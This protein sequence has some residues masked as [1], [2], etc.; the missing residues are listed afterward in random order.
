MQ[1]LCTFLKFLFFF[2]FRSRG[3][4][5]ANFSIEEVKEKCNAE[6]SGFQSACW[7]GAVMT[8]VVQARNGDCECEVQGALQNPVSQQHQ[9][10]ITF[11]S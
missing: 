8:K 7:E 3:P 5:T 11:L 6:K 1:V 2:H 10:P 4:R 9:F